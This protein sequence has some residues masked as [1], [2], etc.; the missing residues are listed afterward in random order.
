MVTGLDPG[1]RGMDKQ[2][3]PEVQCVSP[4]AAPAKFHK[5]HGLNDRHLFFPIP[6]ARCL[7][8]RYQHGHALSKGSRGESFLVSC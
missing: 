4:R 7:K 2:A 3:S 6:G 1:G 5:L 8:S